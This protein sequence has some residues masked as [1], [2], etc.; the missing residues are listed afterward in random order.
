MTN[1]IFD[2]LF[3]KDF[4]ILSFL[5]DAKHNNKV[6]MTQ[7]EIADNFNLSRA[8]VNAIFGRLRKNGFIRNDGSNVGRYILE[9]RGVQTVK[10]FR[11]IVNSLEV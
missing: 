9:Q 4:H 3:T 8:T 11:K 2:E 1:E 6:S 10:Q 7:K 5:Y